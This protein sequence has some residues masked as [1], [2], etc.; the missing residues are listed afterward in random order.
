MTSDLIEASLCRTISP[1]GSL[2]I[3]DWILGLVAEE[4]DKAFV[5]IWDIAKAIVIAIVVTEIGFIAT[6]Q[7]EAIPMN[8]VN[9]KAN[10]APAIHGHGSM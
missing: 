9:I 5:G 10:T 1:A 2:D 8:I 3:S 6:F 4:L 7:L